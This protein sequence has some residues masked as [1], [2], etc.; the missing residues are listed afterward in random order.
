MAFLRGIL[1]VLFPPAC[2]VCRTP[3]QDVLC[4]ICMERIRLIRAPVCERCGKPL[5]GP[6]DLIFT[7]L[8]CQGRRLSFRR[9]RAA[10]IYDGAMREAIHALKFAGRSALAGP[11]GAVMAE[12]ATQWRADPPEAIVPVPLHAVRRR[13]RGFNQAELLAQPVAEALSRPLTPGA[14]TRVRPTDAQS[15][16]DAD[17]RRRNVRRAFAAGVPLDGGILLIDDVFS[18]GC[19]VNECARALRAAGAGY[20]DV[21][22]LAH[23]VLE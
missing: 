14:L 4:R 6:P 12:S 10:G 17:E 23:A 13:E 16:L 1:D 19:T 3:G 11:L 9:A 15:G 20:V 22:T 8:K 7:C 5:R 21:L 18:T 2:Q